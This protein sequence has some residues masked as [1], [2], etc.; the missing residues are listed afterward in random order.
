[1]AFL[2]RDRYATTTAHWTL[3][4]Q[5]SGDHPWGRMMVVSDSPEEIAAFMA[6]NPPLPRI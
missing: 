1:M 2:G 5:L 3:L 4:G 6:R